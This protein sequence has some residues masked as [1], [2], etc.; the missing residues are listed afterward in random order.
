MTRT[1]HPE[2]TRIR[3]DIQR[4]TRPAVV[5]EDARQA[6]ARAAELRAAGLDVEADFVEAQA[7]E[8]EGR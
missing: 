7:R 3:A 6:W 1:E 5:R 8:M 4:C 2:L